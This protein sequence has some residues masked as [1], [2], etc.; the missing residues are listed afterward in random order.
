MA[1]GEAR[2]LRGAVGLYTQLTINS[3]DNPSIIYYDRRSNSVY[4]VTGGMNHWSY[5]QLVLGGGKFIS[6]AVDPNT[7][8][9]VFSWYQLDTNVLRFANT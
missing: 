4:D 6:S 1:N 5:N 9:Q 2:D 7:S 8:D 3:D